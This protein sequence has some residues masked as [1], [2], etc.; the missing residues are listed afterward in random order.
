MH[1]E[2]KG[3]R[4]GERERAGGTQGEITPDFVPPGEAAPSPARRKDAAARRKSAAGAARLADG[5]D[6]ADR[7]FASE[8]GGM[9]STP[10]GAEGK[11]AFLERVPSRAKHAA[12]GPGAGKRNLRAGLKKRLSRCEP[13]I[14]KGVATFR[15]IFTLCSK[16][17][18]KF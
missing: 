2:E 17:K 13:R 5:A 6:P 1:R 18:N 10:S 8:S 11:G 16:K 4:T 12:T 7:L 14:H 15:A 3:W 9:G